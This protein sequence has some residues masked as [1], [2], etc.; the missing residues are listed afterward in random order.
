MAILIKL[1]A[2]KMVAKS[3]FGRSKRP[4]MREAIVVFRKESFHSFGLRE[5]KATSAPEIKA[6]SNN[7]NKT[8]S[9]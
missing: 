5:K 9:D 1:L 8:N 3:L 7:R 6:E 2:I 4:L